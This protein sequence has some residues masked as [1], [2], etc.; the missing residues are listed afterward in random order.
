MNGHQDLKPFALLIAALDPWLGQIVIVGGWA[1]Q[2][3]R[4]HPHAR[5]LDYRPLT[6]LDTDV[7]IPAKMAVGEQ[8]IRQRLL[9]HG[10]VEEFVG[11]HQPPAIHYHLGGEKTGFYAEFL[12]PL[13][14]G[15]HD[16]KH[17]RKAT[18]E[19]AGIDCE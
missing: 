11:D 16:R 7:A 8:D 4:L 6:T 5:G 14:G 17:N 12:T 1:H 18:M 19:I 15:E 3:Y 2:L 13:T 10:F 9:A